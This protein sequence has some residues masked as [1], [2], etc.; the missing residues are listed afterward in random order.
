MFCPLFGIVLV[1]YF[2]LRRGEIDLEDLYK[3]EGKYWFWKGINPMAIIAWAIGFAVYL[4]FSPMLM[5][6]VLQTKAAFPWPLGSSLPSMILGG[7]I[8]GL[9]RKRIAGDKL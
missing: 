8:Y 6:K 7:L 3:K 9:L 1:D 4:G 5:E 2:L